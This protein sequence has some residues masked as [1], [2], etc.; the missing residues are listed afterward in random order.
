MKFKGSREELIA[1]VQSLGYAVETR[2]T[3]SAV[4]IK[5]TDGAILNWY[6][7]TGTINFQGDATGSTQLKSRL[8]PILGS[9]MM[10]TQPAFSPIASNDVAPA[11]VEVNGKVFVVHGHD[12]TSREQLELILHKLGLDPFVLQNTG[13]AGLTIIEAL[14][15][16]IGPN[17]AEVKFGI[18]LLTPDDFGYAKIDGIE[19]AQPR[20]RQ[21]VV[22]EMGMLLS[23]IGR[24]NVAILKKGH[25]DVPSDAQGILYLGFNEHVKEVVPRL[26][27]R[28]T[29]AGF[30][31]DPSNITKASS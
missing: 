30:V 29:N 16:E 12:Q 25:V 24:K 1:K 11:K 21:N 7:S 17:A 4:Q 10:P 2:D 6:P 14:E 20:A 28:L 5:T 8:E 3:A 22:L 31:L 15:Q 19:K 26:V 18:V 23:S 13:G 27:D 9:A